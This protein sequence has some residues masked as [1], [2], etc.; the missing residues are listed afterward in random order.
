LLIDAIFMWFSDRMLF[1]LTT[2]KIGSMT[3]GAGKNRI[4]EPK[5]FFSRKNNAQSVANGDTRRVEIKL[6][7]CDI[8]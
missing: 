6:R 7:Q 4:F 8:C 3:F 5:R 1:T 2:L